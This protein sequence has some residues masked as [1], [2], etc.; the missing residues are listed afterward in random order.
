[1]RGKYVL[2]DFWGSWCGPCIEEL[3]NIKKAYKTFRTENFEIVGFALDNRRYLK[4][5]IKEYDIKWPQILDENGTYQSKFNVYSYPTYY[6]IGPN[7][8]ILAIDKELEGDNLI[9]TLRKYLP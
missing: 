2:L 3:P 6:L 7:G 1:M 9:Q 8:K 4:K 5:A